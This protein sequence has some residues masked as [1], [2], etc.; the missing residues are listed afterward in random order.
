MTTNAVKE[1]ANVPKK[2]RVEI[3]P[4]INILILTLFGI[5]TLYPCLNVVAKAFSSQGYVIT[6]Q[7]YLIPKGLQFG[8]I[9]Y[10]I[11]KP[12]FLNAFKVSVFVT[13]VGTLFAMFLTVLTAYPLSKPSLRGRKFFLGIFVFIMLFGA[14]M[15][16]NYILYRSLHLTN[17][18]WALVFSGAFSVF[19]LFIVKNYYESLPETV[20]EAARI[21]GASNLVTLFRIVLPMS[22][23]VLATVTLFYGV[24]YWNSYFSGVMYITDPSLKSLQQYLYDLITLASMTMDATGVAVADGDALANFTGEV[25]RSATIVVST[26]PILVLY[27]FLQ[28]YFVKGVTIGSVK[29]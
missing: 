28:K 24:S 3:F 15:V 14:G 5:I 21:D 26:V 22:M 2:K 8:T 18:V 20:E 25:V 27:P 4:I 12:D 16:P 6:G 19:N 17:T 10:V 29:G 9:K 13:V 7:V 1:T 23:P 11:S